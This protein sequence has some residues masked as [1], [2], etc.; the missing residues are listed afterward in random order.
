MLD[1][2]LHIPNSGQLTNSRKPPLGPGV[3]VL[4]LCADQ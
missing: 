1:R 4:K 3:S 2:Q